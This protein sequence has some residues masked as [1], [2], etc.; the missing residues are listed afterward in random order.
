MFDLRGY[1]FEQQAQ[2]VTKVSAQSSTLKHTICILHWEFAVKK[3]GNSALPAPVKALV[4][5][6]GACPWGGARSVWVRSCSS[7]ETLLV[8]SLTLLGT[9]AAPGLSHGTFVLAPH[10]V[11]PFLCPLPAEDTCS[12]PARKPL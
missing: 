10:D 9:L 4:P 5:Q 1:Y 11:M 7:T 12:F 3:K 6:A 2:S 8:P